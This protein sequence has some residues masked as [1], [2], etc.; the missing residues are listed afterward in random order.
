[1]LVLKREFHTKLAGAWTHSIKDALETGFGALKHNQASICT[2]AQIFTAA[3]YSMYHKPH[4]LPLHASD[5]A[6]QVLHS[7]SVL[8]F[9]CLIVTFIVGENGLTPAF[10]PSSVGLGVGISCK[11]C[12]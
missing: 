12:E 5:F 6:T 4:T 2:F 9:V 10:T 7:N 11:G 1:M 3:I 8:F